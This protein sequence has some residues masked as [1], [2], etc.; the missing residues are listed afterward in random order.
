MGFTFS[1]RL[2]RSDDAIAVGTRYQI[3]IGGGPIKDAPHECR[4]RG[5]SRL[6]GHV[7]HGA[8]DVAQVNSFEL[9]GSA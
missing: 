1:A 4:E 9:R 3:R 6:P 8:E 5:F 7:R 2:T